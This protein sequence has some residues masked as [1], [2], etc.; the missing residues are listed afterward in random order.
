MANEYVK[1]YICV[2]IMHLQSHVNVH[3]K[4]T[5]KKYFAVSME[6]RVWLR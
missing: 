6:N 2:K 1:I 4:N 3:L 5:I